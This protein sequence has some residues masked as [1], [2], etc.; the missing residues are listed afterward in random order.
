MA[1]TIRLQRALRAYNKKVG[2]PRPISQRSIQGA[3]VLVERIPIYDVKQ[4]VRVYP[5][6]NKALPPGPKKPRKPHIVSPDEFR[7]NKAVEEF[8]AWLRRTGKKL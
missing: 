5:A 8:H 2:Q 4:R 7:A 1:N 3:T 6:Q